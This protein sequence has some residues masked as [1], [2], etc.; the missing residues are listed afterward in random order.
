M[1]PGLNDLM[2][3]D[4]QA[5][6]FFVVPLLIAASIFVMN[7]SRGMSTVGMVAMVVFA[8]I[9]LFFAPGFFQ[10]FS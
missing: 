3:P 10:V 7:L 1:I 6:A 5:I 9:A 2:A 4:M 8:G